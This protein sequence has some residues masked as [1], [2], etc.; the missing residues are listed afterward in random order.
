M[1]VYLLDTAVRFP[2]PHDADSDGLLAV[3]GDLR[4]RRL[5]EA[6][7]KGIFPWYTDDQPILWWSPDPRLVLFPDG[8]HIS[9]SLGKALRRNIFTVSMDTCFAQ[10][11]HLCGTVRSDNGEGTWITSEMEDA[12]CRLHRMGFA[13]SVEVWQ[14]DRLVG[15]LY[16]VSLGKAFFGES[17]FSLER[18][19]SKVALVSLVD[20]VRHHGFDWIDCQVPTQHMLRMGAVEMPRS[21]FLSLLDLALCKPGIP[22][23]WDFSEELQEMNAGHF[24]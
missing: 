15:G 13:H 5:L 24:S 1:T 2:P 21:Q 16:G 23:K 17:M 9:R 18:D 10:V 7:R 6:Y 12:Y 22:G 19:A 4:P 14:G 20:F 3:G 8:L 11:I